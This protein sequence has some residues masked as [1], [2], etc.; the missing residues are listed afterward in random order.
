MAGGTTPFDLAVPHG[1][2]ARD[3]ARKGFIVY[4]MN[5][6]GWEGSTAPVYDES[7]TSLTAAEIHV[8]VLLLRSEYALCSLKDTTT[9]ILYPLTTVPLKA[10]FVQ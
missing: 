10:T 1:S 2:F 6:R 9:T 8:P 4:L 5:V 3:L 7:D